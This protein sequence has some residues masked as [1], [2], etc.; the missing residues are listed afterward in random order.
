MSTIY[1]RL[2][3]LGAELGL[4]RPV[5]PAFQDT[6]A[7]PLIRSEEPGFWCDSSFELEHGLDVAELPIDRLGPSHGGAGPTA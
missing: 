5:Q 3:D 2:R 4:V 6:E 7:A 1:L